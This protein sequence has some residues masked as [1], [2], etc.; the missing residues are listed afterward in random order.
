MHSKIVQQRVVQKFSFA[1]LLLFI[2]GTSFSQQK[3]TITLKQLIDSIQSIVTRDH[4]PGLMLGITAKDSTIFSGGFGYADINARRPV[5][6]TTLFRLGSITKMFVSLSILKLV[7]EGKLNLNDE[8]KKVAPEVPFENKWEATDPVRIV[9]LLE[10]TAGFD[11][12]KLNKMCSQDRMEYAGKDMMLL[13]KKSLISRWK[14]GERHAYSNPGYVI[15]GYIIEKISGQSYSKYVAENILQPL[16]MNETNFN[17]F[18]KMPAKDTKQYVVHRGKII[19]VPSVNVIMAPAGSLWSCADD[20]IKFVRLFLNKGQ[21]VFTDNTINE[22]ETVHSSL[23]AK[24]GLAS[25]YALANTNFFLFNKYP[26]RGHGGLMGTCFST[27]SYNK[28]LGVGFIMSSNGNQQNSQVEK[29]VVDY[30]EQNTPGKKLETVATD[31][32]AIAPFLGQYQFESPR[33]EISGF[34]DKLLNSAKLVAE[35]NSLFIKPLMGSKIKLLQTAPLQFAF[36]G[37]TQPTVVFTKN[38]AGKNI[39]VMNNAYFEQSTFFKVKFPLWLA[40]IAVCF[41]ALSVVTGF[42]SLIG[43]IKHRPTA[44]KLNIRILPMAA[45][46]LL[47]CA[48]K[49]LLEVQNESYLLSELTTI[50]SRTLIIFLG[51]LLF[52]LFAVLHL[53]TVLRKF[54][55]FKNRWFA[56]YWLL[57]SLSIFYIALLLFQN[58]WIGLR[59]WAM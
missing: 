27:C 29:L 59:A 7:H 15:L 34:K 2:S 37:A 35:D 1:I 42:L 48:V 49:Y 38:S 44:N 50:N 6:G 39:M 41:A 22:M 46:L 32:K 55:Q 18:S 40:I 28:E 30:L 56:L 33:I 54:N 58:G 12:M 20:M 52:G 9:N 3:D 13:Q 14:P 19:E 10:H 47:V 45:V 16:A 17:S 25:G 11:D 5:D 43:F 4:V 57:T 36:E 24:A 21:P 53:I 8:L 26:W 51:T 23:A 31:L